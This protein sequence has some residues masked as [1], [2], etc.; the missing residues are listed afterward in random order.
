MFLAILVYMQ[1][2]QNCSHK[3]WHIRTET[4][5]DSCSRV[6]F[7]DTNRE[8]APSQKTPALLE[9]MNMDIWVVGTSNELFI[10]G[11]STDTKFSKK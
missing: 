5:S 9:S 4:V 10:A 3:T 6:S 8:K 11:S 1:E 2:Q 7:K